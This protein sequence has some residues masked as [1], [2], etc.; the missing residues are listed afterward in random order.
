MSYY[1]PADDHPDDPNQGCMYVVSVLIAIFAA[2]GLVI[3]VA[4]FIG[5]EVQKH[6]FQQQ[7][8]NNEAA[9][10]AKATAEVETFYR[11][12]L[13]AAK[14]GTPTQSQI[15]VLGGRN[16]VIAGPS[17]VRDGSIVVAVR[18]QPVWD[19]PTMFGADT[20]IVALC[21]TASVPVAPAT[22]PPPAL[23]RTACPMGG[24]VA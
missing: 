22:T 10:T 18:V 4:L 9:A 7:A 20:D 11:D 2:I 15:H 5:L 24:R 17:V 13:T 23:R 1:H 14:T 3:V 19:V 12:L 16:R 21:Y 8:Q 6:D